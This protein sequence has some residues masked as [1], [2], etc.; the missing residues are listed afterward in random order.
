MHDATSP[1]P[2]RLLLTVSEAARRLGVGRTLMYELISTGQVASVRVGRLRRIRPADLE[3]YANSL[4][5]ENTY[6]PEHAA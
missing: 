1:D 3:A 6:S 4:L 2:T 5:P